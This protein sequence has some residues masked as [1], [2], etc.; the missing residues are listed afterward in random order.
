MVSYNSLRFFVKF[1][2]KKIFL[3]RFFWNIAF[4]A[5]HVLKTI[6]LAAGQVNKRIF[7]NVAVPRNFFTLITTRKKFRKKGI[8]AKLKLRVSP[9][10]GNGFL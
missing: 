10:T 8:T 2:F 4:F 9:F 3:Y 7:S 6:I 5:G 1:L